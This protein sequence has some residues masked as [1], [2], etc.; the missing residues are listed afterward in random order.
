MNRLNVMVAVS[1]AALSLNSLP[2]W[3]DHPVEVSLLVES[4]DG[5]GCQGEFEDPIS[6]AACPAGIVHTHPDCDVFGNDSL[7]HQWRNNG[8][9]TDMFGDNT[10]HSQGYASQAFSIGSLPGIACTNPSSTVFGDGAMIWIDYDNQENPSC[11]SGVTSGQ[12]F[13]FE[14]ARIAQGLPVPAPGQ[15]GHFVLSVRRDDVQ[16]DGDT[17]DV[18]T[19]IWMDMSSLS[20]GSTDTVVKA[21]VLP[22]APDT[23]P[24]EGWQDVIVNTIANAETVY[25]T[26]AKMNLL[27]GLGPIGASVSCA[28]GERVTVRVDDIRYVY[29]GMV[30]DAETDCANGI[31]D[32]MD[33]LIDCADVADCNGTAA[34]PCN[35]V[36]TF[37]TDFDGDV[38]QADFAVFQ[39]CVTGPGPDNPLFASLSALCK[40]LDRTGPGGEKDNAIDQSDLNAFEQCASGPGVPAETGCDD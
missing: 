7:D 17:S 20:T 39:A 18:T 13:D 10:I 9:A 24:D 26:K 37:D 6:C 21:P 36:L 16:G 1:A 22:V 28:L 30:P 11:A 2:V 3:A 4:F 35:R 33:G 32:D 34:C 31:D 38:D 19:T 15:P 27:V 8:W 14:A 23:P 29:T 12:K 25:L 5:C 40:C